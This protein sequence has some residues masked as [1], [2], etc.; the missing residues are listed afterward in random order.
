MKPNRQAPAPRR[1]SGGGA[2]PDWTVAALD[3]QTEVRG[4]IGVAWTQPDGRISIKLNPFLVLDTFKQDLAI[5]LFP[6]DQ[7]RPYA[8]PVEEP[9]KGGQPERPY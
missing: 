9:M 8:E 1:S 7:D 2:Q 3:K 5:S 4:N 6:R